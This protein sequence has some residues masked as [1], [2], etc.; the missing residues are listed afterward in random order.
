M[1]VE[2]MNR[3]WRAHFFSEHHFRY[4]ANSMFWRS[5]MVKSGSACLMLIQAT[6]YGRSNL[7]TWTTNELSLTDSDDLPVPHH[8]SVTEYSYALR[9]P[10]RL[11]RLTL[12]TGR[13]CGAFNTTRIGNRKTTSRLT[14]IPHP[15]NRRHVGRIHL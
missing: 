4:L 13:C 9:L 11:S 14:R 12:P 15:L 10:E 3:D 1:Q 7:H 6:K 2:R 5:S 8:H